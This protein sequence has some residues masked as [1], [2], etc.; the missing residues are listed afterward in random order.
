MLKLVKMDQDLSQHLRILRQAAPESAKVL[1]GRLFHDTLVTTV[2]NRLAYDDFMSR[3]R[4][5]G[6]Y[7]TSDMNSF[8]HINK[9]FGQTTGDVALKASFGALSSAS[10]MFKGKL[11]R[12]GG[13]EAKLFFEKP[14]HAYAFC[15]EARKQLEAL[16]PINGEH[17]HSVS[18]G[19][20]S[21]PD[22]S[23]QALLHAKAAK[24]ATNLPPGQEKTHAYSLINGAS[25]ALTF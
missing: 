10:R 1:S 12:V 25:G 11:F 15:R 19:I 5:G 18:I 17:H 8:G 21:T 7:I 4:K 20:G 16:P 9:K 2:G 23:E 13:D 6:V 24:K 22:E 14:E 3:P